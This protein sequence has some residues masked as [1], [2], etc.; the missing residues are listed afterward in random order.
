MRCLIESQNYKII[1]TF[2]VFRRV[3][4]YQSVIWDKGVVN[5]HLQFGNT[6]TA[7][8]E[9]IYSEEKWMLSETKIANKIE[10][11]RRKKYQK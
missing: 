9:I 2:Q 11:R 5:L 7:K 8:L 4:G 3:S 10:Y 6:F 1:D